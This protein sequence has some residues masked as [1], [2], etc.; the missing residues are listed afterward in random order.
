M[1][2]L[3]RTERWVRLKDALSLA[4][5]RPRHQRH[6]AADAACAGD[7]SLR[8][9]VSALLRAEAAMG[10]FLEQPLIED[11]PA[12][13]DDGPLAPSLR[14]WTRYEIA[15]CLGRGG[16]AAVYKAWDPRLRRFVAIKLIAQSSDAIVHRFLR[17]A[18]SQARV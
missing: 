6:D 5:K 9:E 15:E 2:G 3:V 14:E 17:E 8:D 11:V 16:M 18:E 7:P 4:L 10:S 1:R 13:H 12:T